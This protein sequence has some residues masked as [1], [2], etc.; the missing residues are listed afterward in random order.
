MERTL[1]IL[2][3][4]AVARGLIGEIVSR[5]EK[6]GLS[7][8]GLKMMQ[9]S[10]TLLEQ[11][12]SHLAHKPF[13]A[14]IKASMKRTPVVVACVQGKDSVAVVRQLAGV[15]NGR[16]AAPGTIRGDFS[17]SVSENIIHASDSPENALIEINRFFHPEEIFEYRCVLS[18]VLYAPDE[19]I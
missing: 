10:D 19:T 5:L 9:L 2:K 12:Y 7:F 15:T 13:F 16:E 14:S 11:H 8:V 6:K 1:I 3:P 18:E 4:S 17:M